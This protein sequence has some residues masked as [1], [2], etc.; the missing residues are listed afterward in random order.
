M[1]QWGSEA[2]GVRG[3]NAIT[4]LKNYYGSDIEYAEAVAISGTPSSYPGYVLRRGASGDNITKM[5]NELNRIGQNYPAIPQTPVTGVFDAATEKAVRAFQKVFGLVQDGLVGPNTWY[6]ISY[7]YTAVKRLAELGAEGEYPNGEQYP[8]TPLKLGSRGQSVRKI[9]TWLREIAENK[10]A[11]IPVI[12]VDGVFGTATQN[13]V[14]IFQ[15]G[16]GLTTDG[17]VGPTTWNKIRQVH[18]T[19]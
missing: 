9:Q 6:K 17:I 18:D 19:I 2:L 3:Y 16:F 13:A 15:Q 7:I 5:Q 8:G 14:K 10:Y 12:N 4:I 11:S 1:S